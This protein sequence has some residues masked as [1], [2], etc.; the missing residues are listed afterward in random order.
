MAADCGAVCTHAATACIREAVAAAEAEVLQGGSGRADAVERQLLEARLEVTAAHFEG[1]LAAVAPCSLRG[2]AVEVPRTSW[3]DIG[4]QWAVK[5]EL[6]V[7]STAF[8]YWQRPICVTSEHACL[9][10][11]WA[12]ARL[13]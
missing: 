6:Q 5:R 3:D 2:V 12:A 4:G 10:T 1:A 11:P 9:G 7:N 13:A 8:L